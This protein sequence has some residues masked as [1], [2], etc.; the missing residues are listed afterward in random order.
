MRASLSAGLAALLAVLA[1][2]VAFAR[3]AAADTVIWTDSSAEE[4]VSVQACTGFDIVTSY[5][6]ERTYRLVTGGARYETW[7]QQQVHFAGTFASATTSASIAY[8]GRYLRTTDVAAGTVTIS[9]LWLQVVPPDAAPNVAANTRDA[10]D[11]S[12]AVIWQDSLRPTEPIEVTASRIAGDL[13]DSPPAIVLEVGPPEVTWRLCQLLGGTPL[14]TPLTPD[15][16]HDCALV[17]P[18]NAKPC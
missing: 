3:P 2:W 7:E 11:D 5:S 8:A 18:Q 10:S 13:P 6:V 15:E 14:E 1:L 4:N 12:S 17:N 9:N 16:L